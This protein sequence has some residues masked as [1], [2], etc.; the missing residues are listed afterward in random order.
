MILQAKLSGGCLISLRWVASVNDLARMP[1]G[2]DDCG[3]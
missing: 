3:L 1:N 2:V